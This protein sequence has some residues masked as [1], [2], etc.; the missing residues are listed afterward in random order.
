M[1]IDLKGVSQEIRDYEFILEKG[2]WHPDDAADPIQAIRHP[3]V[4]NIAIYRAGNKY[5]LDGKLKGQLILICDR[6]LDK[7]NRESESEFKVFFASSD[8]NTK[9][10]IELSDHDLEIEQI[11]GEEIELDDIIKEQIYLT[12]PI[13]CTC[14]GDCKGICP[15]CGANLNN[16]DCQCKKESGHPGFAKLKNFKLKEIK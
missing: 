14:S 6:C 4:V 9:S 16:E 1:I 5:I 2:W 3:F 13:R 11:Q 10:E 8:P 7:F 15:H 12:L